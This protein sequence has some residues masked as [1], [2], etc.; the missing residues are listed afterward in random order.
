MVG[1]II[2]VFKSPIKLVGGYLAKAG[3][4][5]QQQAYARHHAVYPHR[6]RHGLLPFSKNK[7]GKAAK[8]GPKIGLTHTKRFRRCLRA[9]VSLNV[10]RCY[11][12]LL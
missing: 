11:Y 7:L 8:P 3:Y 4:A 6:Y 12:Y 2:S 1:C 9:R 10:L 5:R